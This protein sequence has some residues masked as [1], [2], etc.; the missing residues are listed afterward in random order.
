VCGDDTHAATDALSHFGNDFIYISN[1]R[2]EHVDQWSSFQVFPSAAMPIFGFFQSIKFRI[3]SAGWPV[4]RVFF[5]IKF[6]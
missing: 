4:E 3:S 2:R 1:H 6:G 5:L